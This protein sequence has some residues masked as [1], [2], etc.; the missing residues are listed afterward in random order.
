[1]ATFFEK[2]R[3]Q[4]LTQRKSQRDAKEFL[5]QYRADDELVMKD[6]KR[7][8]SRDCSEA[9]L[10]HAASASSAPA[11]ATMSEIDSFFRQQRQLQQSR[12]QDQIKFKESLH[13]H[14]SQESLLNCSSADSNSNNLA[15]NHHHPMLL[16]SAS[17][18]NIE[19]QDYRFDNT[20]T[21]IEK[22]LN[23]RVEEAVGSQEA[24][25]IR[26]F[27]DMLAAK[28]ALPPAPLSPVQDFDSRTKALS[29]L[30]AFAM[31]DP[32]PASPASSI[33]IS[34]KLDF[35]R[36]CAL[37][38]RAAPALPD[39]KEISTQ[40]SEEDLS[41]ADSI[42]ITLVSMTEETR[43]PPGKEST[44]QK[45]QIK[46]ST[47]AKSS[48]IKQST[49]L[50]ASRSPRRDLIMKGKHHK[51]KPAGSIPE[52]QE[53]TEEKARDNSCT[54]DASTVEAPTPTTPTTPTRN[55][56][57]HSESK[58]QG[59]NSTIQ[60]RKS[61]ADVDLF[62]KSSP[63]YSASVIVNIA[64]KK[65][66]EVEHLYPTI[67]EEAQTEPPSEAPSDERKEKSSP[68]EEHPGA[69]SILKAGC[70]TSKSSNSSHRIM[71]TKFSDDT[72][73]LSRDSYIAIQ[74]SRSGFE[75]AM[76]I[77]VDEQ[78]LPSK[79]DE[80]DVLQWD[81]SANSL[82][83][84]TEISCSTS[85]T[86]IPTV[87]TYK[88]SATAHSFKSSATA[89][90]DA[91]LRHDFA[92]LSMNE[93]DEE[94]LTPTSAL[95]SLLRIDSRDECNA[96][97]GE[98][99]DYTSALNIEPSG[100]KD[101]ISVDPGLVGVETSSSNETPAIA[102]VEQEKKP[103]YDDVAEDEADVCSNLN[104]ALEKTSPQNSV[105]PDTHIFSILNAALE[106]TPPQMNAGPFMIV[107][108][109]D[110]KTEDI[111]VPDT[112]PESVNKML[113]DT[114]D[115]VVMLESVDSYD[116]ARS[117]D[118]VPVTTPESVNEM[119]EDTAD[120]VVMLESV[121]SY[122][123][124]RSSDGVPVTTPESVNEMLE[125][126]ADSV[127]MLESVDSYDSA[128]SSDDSFSIDHRSFRSVAS[129]AVLPPAPAVD[130]S[131]PQPKDYTVPLTARAGF[132][133][134]L[135][136]FGYTKSSP[137]PS[138][139]ATPRSSRK[140]GIVTPRARTPM[141]RS[142]ALTSPYVRAASPA[143]G[144]DPEPTGS[145]R[146]DPYEYAV[147]KRNR[148][149]IS[150]PSP[151]LEKTKHVL[152]RVPLYL[153]KPLPMKVKEKEVICSQ[154]YDPR[155]HKSRAGC[156]RCLHWASQEEKEMFEEKG[157]HHRIMMVRGGCNQGCA[158]FPRETDEFPVR[159][160]V[161]CYYDTHKKDLNSSEWDDVCTLRFH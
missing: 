14:R 57:T 123:S 71:C 41:Y 91:C 44:N 134:P 94:A 127:M 102:V 135:N 16:V 101:T 116:S 85:P 119:L 160:C 25:T 152:R 84:V 36:V 120:S 124:A 6:I 73:H 142:T 99:F 3:E 150:D 10:R 38:Q 118:G 58:M 133:T 19:L 148:P 42:E 18:E 138:Q 15:K 60:T 31:Q 17:S 23:D 122:D 140:S 159:L 151:V 109:A 139:A 74:A 96:C 126:T 52:S 40:Q 2:Q 29:E 49:R 92:P 50:N 21:S 110:Q 61:A 82:E 79:D 39:I 30:L 43:K 113:E 104:T 53:W 156:E 48:D 33:L 141:K 83:T 63:Y 86:D 56:K 35:P 65:E 88:S 12:S 37:Q 28:V 72:D 115:S 59:P 13:T 24:E 1:M 93:S 97:E 45:F 131:T 76:S 155:L 54:V 108:S 98:V 154:K 26:G 27:K 153:R 149:R 62:E 46:T 5:H 69:P 106:K 161:K 144:K 75:S 146:S 66:K 130:F 64:G 125:D 51:P 89:H 68:N 105:D 81:Q 129:S 112:T 11:Y 32:L 77:S 47:E 55:P 136:I 121:D 158:V 34:Q 157:H 147:A 107:E 114:A 9:S 87:N 8:T 4:T 70:T 111:S 100:S 137:S 145:R 80:T 117:S 67:A 90:L 143:G 78:T 103:V 7:A 132:G 20:F 128:R 22:A 95:N